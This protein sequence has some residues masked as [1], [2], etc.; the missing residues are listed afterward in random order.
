MA[1]ARLTSAL[2]ITTALLAAAPVAASADGVFAS[3]SAANKGARVG[4]ASASH[5]LSILLTL[6][7]DD[8]ALTAYASA[9]SNPASPLYGKYLK[10]EQIARR[11]GSSQNDRARVTKALRSAGLTPRTGLGGFWIETEATVAQAGALFS[12]GFASYRARTSGKRY[13]APTGEPQLPQSLAGTVTGV[14]GLSDAPVA[15]SGR[16]SASASQASTLPPFTRAENREISAFMASAGSSLRGNTGT[17]LGCAAGKAA[18]TPFVWPQSAPANNGYVPAYTPNQVNAAYG[19]RSLHSKGLKGQGQRIALIEIGGFSRSDLEIA[20]ACFGY[21]APPTPIKLIGLKQP[22]PIDDEATLDLQVIA[23]SAPGVESIRVIEAANTNSNLAKAFASAIE[24][25]ASYR[26]SVI[27][28]SIGRCEWELE[29]AAQLSYVKAMERILKAAAVEGITVAADSGD[30]GSTGCAQPGNQSALTIPSVQYPAS[31]PW[32]TGVGGTN[33]ELSSANKITEEVVWNDS[34]PVF[35]SGTGGYSN[36]FKKPSWQTG[37]GV[38]SGKGARSV[39]DVALLADRV[40]GYAIYCSSTSAC[41]GGWSPVGGTSAATPLFASGVLIANQQAKAAGQAHL[42]FLNKK[43]YM[44]A[45]NSATRTKAFRDVTK[46]GNDLGQMIPPAYK[47]TGCCAATKY[48]D[49]ASGW[50][51]VNFPSFSFEARKLGGQAPSGV[52]GRYGR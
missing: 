46:I 36:F 27:S 34:P 28:T 16:N 43:I 37:P 21:R 8:A 9:V 5:R 42:G 14:V 25:P 41:L 32:A 12:T 1:R 45:G 4:A 19:L 6:R 7:A 40:P 3:T 20:A 31:S 52:T 24:A 50:G 18:G 13:V 29:Q 23:A 49:R 35:G 33:F 17:Q 15:R 48:Y 10:P 44:L 11:F 47:A 39:P 38:G 51:S 2:L 30:T 26:P 22:L